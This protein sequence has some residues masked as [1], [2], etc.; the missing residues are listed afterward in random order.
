MRVWTV[1][2]CLVALIA[3][4]AAEAKPK[5][6]PTKQP[7]QPSAISSSQAGP[8]INYGVADNTS[9]FADDGGAWFYTKL[10]GANLTENRWEIQ[11]DASSP[12]SIAQL[13]FLQ[14]AAPA[15]Q[16]AW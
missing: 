4:T 13:G 3:A 1:A 9:F 16:A 7:K 8:A 15:A 2:A 12:S 10:K 6:K 11:W 5:P 14:R